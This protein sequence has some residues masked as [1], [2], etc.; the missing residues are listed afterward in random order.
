MDAI[1]WEKVAGARQR[2]ASGRF[3]DCWRFKWEWRDEEDD[4]ETGHTVTGYVGPH[5]A[6]ARWTAWRVTYWDAEHNNRLCEYR[7]GYDGSEA[8]AKFRAAEAAQQWLPDV[9]SRDFF[10]RMAAGVIKHFCEELSHDRA[11]GLSL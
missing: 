6:D 4:W 11:A 10:C 5:E 2:F 3:A 8:G 7:G 1:I 9:V